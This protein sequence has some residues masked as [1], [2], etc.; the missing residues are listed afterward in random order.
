MRALAVT[1]VVL[2]LIVG[3]AL[4]IGS[5]GP[6]DSST[7]VDPH[8]IEIDIDGGHK[9]KKPKTNKAPSYRTGTSTKRR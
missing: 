8:G 2:A 1:L 7:G 9:A 4:L 5:C 6:Q 3:G